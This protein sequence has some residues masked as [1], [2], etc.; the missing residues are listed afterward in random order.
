M[1]TTLVNRL[2]PGGLLFLGPILA[3]AIHYGAE[4]YQADTCLDQG[5]SFDYDT[6][7]CSL[8]Q[9]YPTSPYLN[10]HWVKVVLASLVSSAGLMLMWRSVRH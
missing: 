4:V 6:Q 9:S 10:R 3:L 8:A 2:G 7:T 5:G 1:A